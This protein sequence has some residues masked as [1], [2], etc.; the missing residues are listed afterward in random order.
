[1]AILFAIPKELDDFLP[2]LEWM[3][4]VPEEELN[5]DLDTDPVIQFLQARYGSL[6]VKE[7]ERRFKTDR[8]HFTKLLEAHGTSHSWLAYFEA[9]MFS[10]PHIL[11]DLEQHAADDD[12][13]PPPLIVHVD[14]PP[15]FTIENEYGS[16]RARNESIELELVPTAESVLE[17]KLHNL[18]QQDEWHAKKQWNRYQFANFDWGAVNGWKIVNGSSSKAKYFTYLLHVPGGA[19]FAEVS[20]RPGTFDESFVETHLRSIKVTA[21]T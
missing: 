3:S 11:G 19:C 14:L 2:I 1:M 6:D 16:I 21:T 12:H 18:R 17:Y 8:K 5:E 4:D 9:V 10:A 20:C 15:D 13:T 7:F